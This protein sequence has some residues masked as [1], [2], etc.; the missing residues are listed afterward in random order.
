MEQKKSVL[1]G[2]QPSGVLT[3]GNYIGALRNWAKLQA[4]FN[5]YYCVVDMHSITVRQ[6]PE[7]LRR[8]SIE[9]MALL[10]ACGVKPE[11]STMFI[12]SHVPAHAQLTWVLSCNTY[13]GE[14]SRMTQFKDKSARHADNIN[15]GLFTYPVLMAAD[16]L[17]YQADLVPVGA[18]QKQH[19]EITRDVAIRFNNAYGETFT[20]PEPYI[21]EV[22]AKV[23]S[24]QEPDRKMSKSDDNPNAYIALLDTPDII[25]KKMKRAVTDSENCIA[26]DENRPGVAN[27]L[28]IYSA[29][30]GETIPEAVARFEGKGYG[31]LKT[32]AAAAV[33]SVLEPVQKEFY[34]V[35]EEKDYLNKT[36][37]YG[38]EKAG[39]TANR[40]LR[41]VY[42]KVGFNSFGV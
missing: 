28:S 30:A 38:A 4:D 1:S 19:I 7:A 27:L 40:T 37:R 25:M 10:I 5:A 24:L 12:Q 29:C 22:G 2:I 11:T 33:I 14:L 26:Y 13:M 16:I 36:I 9:T 3:L 41:D 35:L 8:R 34:R 42:D 32:A 23:M 15:A 20:L 18:D 21:P 31:A 39:E 6:D 17:L